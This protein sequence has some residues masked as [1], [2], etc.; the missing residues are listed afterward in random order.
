[1]IAEPE[2]CKERRVEGEKVVEL[3]AARSEDSFSASCSRRR[4]ACCVLAKS[5][6]DIG[7]A[8]VFL[9]DVI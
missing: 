7:V 3:L 5:G 8:C 4:S 9:V 1:M 6:M 2:A